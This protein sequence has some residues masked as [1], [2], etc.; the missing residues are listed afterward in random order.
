M[1]R[2]GLVMGDHDLAYQGDQVCRAPVQL[3]G[4]TAQQAGQIDQ[5]VDLR[6]H[7]IGRTVDLVKSPQHVLKIRGAP[8]SQLALHQLSEPFDGRQ[9]SLQVVR[10]RC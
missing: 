1:R 3:R 7:L 5:L 6:L 2:G 9:R 8:S 4:L 10:D